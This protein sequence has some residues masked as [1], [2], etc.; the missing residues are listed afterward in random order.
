MKAGRVS[1]VADT[2]VPEEEQ[3]LWGSQWQAEVR[4]DLRLTSPR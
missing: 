4:P 1:D 2:R 3:L